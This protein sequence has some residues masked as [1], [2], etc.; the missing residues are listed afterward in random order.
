[1]TLTN[2][3]YGRQNRHPRQVRA[4][5]RHWRRL[6]HRADDSAMRSVQSTDS[7]LER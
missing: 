1:M 7:V 2:L 3:S 5:F 4:F 6:P